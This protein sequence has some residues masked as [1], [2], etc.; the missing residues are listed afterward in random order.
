MSRRTEEPLE[1]LQQ[2][3]R[4]KWTLTLGAVVIATAACTITSAL[5]GSF[6]SEGLILVEDRA[7]PSIP[8]LNAPAANAPPGPNRVRTE[9]DI[10]RSRKIAE[11]VVRQLQLADRPELLARQWPGWLQAWA[12]RVHAAIGDVLGWDPVASATAN[13]EAK[14][15][16]AVQTLRRRLYVEADARSYVISV[17]FSASSAEFAARVVNAVMDTYVADELA[18]REKVTSQANRWL[19][20][21]LETLRA[22]VEDADRK[23]QD[24]RKEN[25]VLDA[26]LQLNNEET[27]LAKLRQDLAKAEAALATAERLGGRTGSAAAIQESQS[28]FVVQQLRVREAEITQRLASNRTLGPEH[29]QRMADERALADVRREIAAEV[30]KVVVSLRRDVELGRSRVAAMERMVADAQD[31]GRLNAAANVKLDQLKDERDARARVYHAFLTRTEQTRLSSAQFSS[32]RIVSPAR[33]PFRP[34]GPL[35]PIVGVFAAFVGLFGTSFLVVGRHLLRDRVGSPRDLE[36]LGTASIVGSLPES[37]RWARRGA[38]GDVLMTRGAI[39][40]TLRG[41]LIALRGLAPS[42]NGATTVLVTSA[43]RGDGKSTIAASLAGI[44]AL[45]GMRVLLVEADL[46]RPRLASILGREPVVSFEAALAGEMPFADA[47]VV[48]AQTGL[49]GLVASGSVESPQAA[50]QSPAFRELIAWARRQYDVVILDSPPIL[51]VA[52][53]VLLAGHSDA[54]LFA[55]GWQRIS[56]TLLAEAIER[57]PQAMRARVLPVLTRVPPRRVEHQG[58]FQGYGSVAAGRKPNASMARPQPRVD[59]RDTLDERLPR[60]ETPSTSPEEPAYREPAATRRRPPPR[61]LGWAPSMAVAAAIMAA[62]AMVAM[63]T[64]GERDDEA[65]RRAAADARR[66]MEEGVKLREA[67]RARPKSMAEVQRH[68]DLEAARRLSEQRTQTEAARK[69]AEEKAAAEERART[70]AAQEKAEAEARAAAQDAARRQ[71]AEDARL[72]AAAE[73]RRAAV[74][75]VRSEAVVAQQAEG[76]ERGLNLTDIDRKRAQAAL[77]ALGFDI[78]GATGHFGP[79]TRAMV[80]LW[81]KAQGLAQTGF[82][83]EAQL[84]ALH[85]QA[86]Q[87]KQQGRRKMAEGPKRAELDLRYPADAEAALNLSEKDR[88]RVQEALTSLGHVVGTPTGHFG[89]HTRTMIT[90]WQKKQGLPETGFLT[91]PQL[92]LLQQQATA[93]VTKVEEAQRSRPGSPSSR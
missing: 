56:R 11:S 65:H 61:R 68:A 13:P 12:T 82:L 83:D 27:Q 21:R 23:V 54:I 36:R 6:T 14:E 5:P 46:R 19:R 52:D 18:A 38:S 71:S 17:R 2:L 86:D 89:Q 85:Q 20:E 44:G 49:H 22:E 87:A 91:A 37:R 74:A 31:R 39:A 58:V 77:I 32:A 51:R 60:L 72:R 47:V 66:H 24:F 48:D 30:A 25:G 78:G 35:L 15:D 28:S 29:P 9:A 64:S 90:A 67:E 59:D 53:P 1:L 73:A 16:V 26:S 33:P 10:I 76:V 81:Q 84:V 34:D 88:K 50:L 4:R 80:K 63:T 41:L 70:A 43:E 75:P 62:G 79:R 92:A 45:D 8:E 40:E 55:V 69:A 93:A 42:S 7:P 57:L 3:W